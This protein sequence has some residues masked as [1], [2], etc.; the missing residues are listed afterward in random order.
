MARENRFMKIAFDR[1]IRSGHPVSMAAVLVKSG[2]IISIGHNKT[3]THPKQRNRINDHGIE[4]GNNNIHAE[5]DA[6]VRAPWGKIPGSTIYVARRTR[7]DLPGIARP[8]SSCV[9]FLSDYGVKRAYYTINRSVTEHDWF[10][11]VNL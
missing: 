11:L 5:V 9:D 1:T 2:K 3:K 4:Y 7:S 8:C 10:D 6:L